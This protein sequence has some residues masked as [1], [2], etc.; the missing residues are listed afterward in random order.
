MQDKSC[1]QSPEHLEVDWL[2][3]MKRLLK[4]QEELLIYI[5]SEG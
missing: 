1:Y 2:E 4:Q 3:V 5:C